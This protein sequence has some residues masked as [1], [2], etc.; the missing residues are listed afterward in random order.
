MTDPKPKEERFLNRRMNVLSGKFSTTDCVVNQFGDA[1]DNMI[2]W[3]HQICEFGQLW[4]LPE[5]EDCK[6]GS[7][8]WRYKL[9]KIPFLTTFVWIKT[10]YD[11]IWN[12]FVVQIYHTAMWP[13][14]GQTQLWT[15]VGH[16]ANIDSNYFCLLCDPPVA[17]QF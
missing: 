2:R 7:F 13:T 16:I 14:G 17:K 11:Q 15:R 4:R 10:L 12:I 3:S 5:G 8:S 9:F 6:I 1:S